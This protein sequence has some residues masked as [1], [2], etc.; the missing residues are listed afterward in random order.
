[1]A[2]QNEIY[3]KKDVCINLIIWK[4]KEIASDFET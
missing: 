4:K 2:R 3:K 1:M